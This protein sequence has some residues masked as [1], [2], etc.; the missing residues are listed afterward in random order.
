M[1]G[2]G[3]K[4]IKYPESITLWLAPKTKREFTILTAFL[5]MTQDE[6]LAELIRYYKKDH[7]KKLDL[8]GDE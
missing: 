8:W 2:D 1:I 7:K 5:E 3:S 6:M 4:R